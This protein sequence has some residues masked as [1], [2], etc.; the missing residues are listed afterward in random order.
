MQQLSQK[1][2]IGLLKSLCICSGYVTLGNSVI[3][4]YM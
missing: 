4:N 2:V 3:L 1:T